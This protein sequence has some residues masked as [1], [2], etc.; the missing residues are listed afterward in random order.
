[1]KA[2]T[3]YPFFEL[4]DVYRE[5]APVRECRVLTYD[6][7]KYVTIEVGGIVKDVKIG[8]VYRR[9]GRCGEVPSIDKW[10]T[11]NALGVP[12]WKT[13]KRREKKTGWA[14]NYDGDWWNF[15]TKREAVKVILEFPA[16]AE[17]YSEHVS[18]NRS[19]MKYELSRIEP[20]P[21]RMKRRYGKRK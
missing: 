18:N 16:G 21:Y 4:G 9:K 17:L 11:F 14:I 1:M 19:W 13:H 6:C 8:Y 2:W 12:Y 5:P 7:N 10:K 15:D 3:D 20:V